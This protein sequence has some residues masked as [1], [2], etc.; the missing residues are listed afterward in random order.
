MGDKVV[1]LRRKA[2]AVHG[3]DGKCSRNCEHLVVNHSA[4]APT[5]WDED[6]CRPYF[7]CKFFK[8]VISY[9]AADTRPTTLQKCSER[10]ERC[11][12]LDS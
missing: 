4:F 9:S 6:L 10:T 12:K 11:P 3:E 5:V 1:T 2:T 7:F 8:R